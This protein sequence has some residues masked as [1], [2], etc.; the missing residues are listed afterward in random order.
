M[1]KK[2]R[3]LKCFLSYRRQDLIAA[4]IIGRI[5]DRL[6]DCLGKGNVFMDVD[7]IAPGADFRKVIDHAV[8]QADVLLVM[9][10]TQWTELM[11][12]RKPDRDDFV[13]IEIEAAFNRGIPV[14]PVLIGASSMP[15]IGDLPESLNQL[16]YLN[17]AEVDPGKHF[18][19]NIGRLVQE[20]ENHYPKVVEESV[21]LKDTTRDAPVKGARDVGIRQ[22]SET[23]P[24]PVPRPSAHQGHSVA[25]RSP[26]AIVVGLLLGLGFMVYGLNFFVNI[27]PIPSTAPVDSPSAIFI[28]AMFAAN[29]LAFVKVLEIIGGVLIVIPKT[30]SL[31]LLVLGPILVNILCYH[32]FFKTGELLSLPHIGL[33]AL[34]GAM[35]FIDYKRFRSLL[36]NPKSTKPVPMI[37]GALLGLI[38]IVYGLNFFLYFIPTPALPEGTAGASFMG[39]L[40]SSGYLP[41]VMILEILGGILTLIPKTKYFGLLILV[42]IWVNIICFHL[43]FETGSLFS[44][45]HVVVT[46]FVIIILA[47][48]SRKFVELFELP[49]IQSP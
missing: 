19:S 29:Y 46:L 10:G 48:D 3:K 27:I 36:C 38:F 13:R 32:I 21:R 15:S 16:P 41:F 43:F 12:Q 49:Q 40:Y 20:L 30:R 14:V 45:L 24:D 33:S 1:P 8:G 5:F 9:I 7:S 18:N 44:P 4:G 47:Y 35:L 6:E 22:T 26:A 11:R 2:S 28:G 23:K 25:N 39:A 42:P 37:I 31:G 34:A 17:A